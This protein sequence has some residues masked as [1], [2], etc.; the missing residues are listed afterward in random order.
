MRGISRADAANL[1]RYF[2]PDT[3][4]DVAGS[5]SASAGELKVATNCTLLVILLPIWTL[6]AEYTRSSPD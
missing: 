2:L 5:R 4:H 1:I 6:N 3:H